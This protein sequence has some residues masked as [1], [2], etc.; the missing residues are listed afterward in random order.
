MK[1]KLKEIIIKAVPE[2]VELKFG[3]VIEI[4]IFHSVNS[5]SSGTYL[6]RHTVLTRHTVNGALVVNRFGRYGNKTIGVNDDFETIGR[7]IRLADVLLALWNAKH[8][9]R[10]ILLFIE[11][12]CGSGCGSNENLK[13][14]WNLKENDLDKQSDET[15]EFLYNLLK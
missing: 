11:V 13:K 10:D 5:V 15:I 12:L 8:S 1:N 6:R 9:N 14:G 3:C 4:P 7:P 2:I